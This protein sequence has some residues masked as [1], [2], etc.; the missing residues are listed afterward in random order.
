MFA[1]TDCEAGWFQEIL[2]AAHAIAAAAVSPPS[3]VRILIT[4]TP[5]LDLHHRTSHRHETNI[6]QK[7]VEEA[8]ESLA[9]KCYAHNFETGRGISSEGF[10]SGDPQLVL[11]SS[12]RKSES[13][14]FFPLPRF[15]LA[16]A[17]ALC[18][19]I[20]AS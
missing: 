6:F 4:L 10:Q 2:E 5:A 3:L 8:I 15:F 9:I 13:A 19:S 12:S 1:P 7:H 11:S 17:A 20:L 18:L 14:Y 16:D